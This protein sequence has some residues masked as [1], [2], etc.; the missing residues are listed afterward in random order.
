[1]L[2]SFW[3]QVVHVANGMDRLITLSPE[4]TKTY[5]RLLGPVMSVHCCIDHQLGG[6]I[7]YVEDS[8][9]EQ[10]VLLGVLLLHVDSQNLSPVF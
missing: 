7:P 8:D 6:H 1:M 4:E 5:S 3:S 10:P 2:A 9:V